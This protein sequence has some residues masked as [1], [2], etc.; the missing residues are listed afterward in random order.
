M[1]DSP[2]LREILIS[3]VE[4]V[5]KEHISDK[6]N[7][8]YIPSN[9]I[10]RR[11][12]MAQ[13]F[14]TLIKNHGYTQDDLRSGSVRNAI[15]DKCLPSTKVK[16]IKIN[17]ADWK[18]YVE[19]DYDF[20]LNAYFPIEILPAPDM[21]LFKDAEDIPKRKEKNE[22]LEKYA[23]PENLNEIKEELEKKTPKIQPMDWSLVKRDPDAIRDVLD[24]DFLRELESD[25]E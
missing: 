10:E 5:G 23:N 20:L 3:W 8:K 7:F 14:E 4:E 2:S 6:A 12:L 25:D 18:F 16:N 19:S 13:L 11:P 21:D 24:E 1:N 22:N 17:R 9:W 15:V